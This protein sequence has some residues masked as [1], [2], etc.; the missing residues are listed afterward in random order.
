MT[1][2]R[3][4]GPP[5]PDELARIEAV[6]G[7][8][9]EGTVEQL[10]GRLSDPSWLVRRAVVAALARIGSSVD[11]LCAVLLGE[12]TDEARLAAAVE[13]LCGSI[14][15]ADDAVLRLLDE[16]HSAAVRCDAAQ[17]LGRR[18]CARAIPALTRLML[19]NDDNVATAAVEAL[20]RI[21]G[22]GAVDALTAAVE[23]RSFFRTFPAISPLGRS[24][25]PRAIPPL[26]DLLATPRY[27]AEAAEALGHSAHPAATRP[28][29]ALLVVDD[30]D[31]L[32]R[33]AVRALTRLRVHH[34]ARFDQAFR[35][36]TS[37]AAFAATA[38]GRLQACGRGAR[39]DDKVALSSVLGW[40][41]D[42]TATATL[43]EAVRESDDPERLRLLSLI[44]PTLAR[45]PIFVACLTDA[46]ARVRAHACRAVAKV[47]D[48]S[49]V[50]ALF[51]LIGDTNAY[52][53]QASIAAVEAL[54]CDQTRTLALEAAGSTDP[55]RRRA[56]LQIIGK[57]AYPEAL[58]LMTAA[59]S[60]PNERI[61]DT[62]IGALAS[63]NDPRALTALLGASASPT[64]GARAAAM[65]ALGRSTGA[66]AV[67]LRA[68]VRDED[69]WVRYYACQALG[70]LAVFE[71]LDDVI[72]L[73]DDPAGQV[74]VAAIEAIAK[75]GD[76]RSTAVMDTACRSVDPDIRRVA[77]LGLGECKRSEA[78]PLLLREARSDDDASR[79][80]ALSALAGSDGD[81][82]T[83]ALLHATND[84][85][86]MVQS[87]AVALLHVR[88]GAAA[89][90]WLIAQL[91]DARRRDDA[92]IALEQPVAGRVEGIA[93]ALRDADSSLTPLLITALTNLASPESQ[94]AIDAALGLENVHA[95]RS[96]ARALTASDTADSRLLLDRAGQED[97]D[98]EVRRIC[99][100]GR[101]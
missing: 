79:L 19:D 52:V 29:V 7:L 64:A 82:A 9:R 90:K 75:L 6:A 71:A 37:D 5:V 2:P 39:A 20:G 42:D 22:G 14:G 101:R 54:R 66:A 59:L 92:R 11:L 96:A 44:E 84:S 88:T 48:T 38:R 51:A 87:A 56:A 80:Y 60:D 15:D 73:I 89:T 61:R 100:A 77:I 72:A 32:V 18:R 57:L 28:L 27:A 68:G 67:A 46:D 16:G 93:L 41:H 76:G 21:G 12:R 81:E 62:A 10:I 24:N 83:E 8:A 30:D 69:A 4:S 55:A 35:E 31:A 98:D 13:A 33:A 23:S 3:I 78:L 26:V 43:L 85:V 91:G 1:I 50:P 65:R 53:S 17:V 97:P 36:A 70:N 95:R 74:R 49:V 94:A 99:A 45:L 86:G 25:D 34:E 58:Y 40:L 63:L 47:G